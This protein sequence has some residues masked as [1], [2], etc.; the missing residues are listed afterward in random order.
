[1]DQELLVSFPAPGRLGI[2]VV[3]EEHHEVVGREI[4]E[5]CERPALVRAAGTADA[6]REV[7]ATS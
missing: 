7:P 5:D 2:G 3:V 6:F 4:V 1:M